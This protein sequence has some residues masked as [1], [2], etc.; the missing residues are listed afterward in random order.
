ML[1]FGFLSL[2]TELAGPEVAWTVRHGVILVTTADNARG[3]L[4][5]GAYDVRMLTA[6]RTDFIV[7]R[8]QS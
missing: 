3:A 1:I 7:R 6:A 5:F 2:I 8:C 4:H